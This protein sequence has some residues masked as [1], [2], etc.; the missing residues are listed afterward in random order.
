M[1]EKKTP[2]KHLTY[3][4][5]MESQGFSKVCVY[6]PDPQQVIDYASKKRKSYLK[7]S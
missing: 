4:E 1:S 6:A 5:K 7:K 2:K 3:K